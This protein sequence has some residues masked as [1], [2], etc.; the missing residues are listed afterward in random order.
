MGRMV[1]PVEL[2][3]VDEDSLVEQMTAVRCWL[4]HQ[5]LEPMVFRYSFFGSAILFRVEFAEETE[6][7]A[8]A[9]AFDGKILAH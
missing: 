7:I 2:K 3:I 8:F 4:D 5:R 1:F 6:A 9:T